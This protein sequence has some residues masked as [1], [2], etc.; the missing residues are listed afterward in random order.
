MP[1]L[2][3][4]AF[5]CLDVSPPLLTVPPASA[6]AQDHKLEQQQEAEIARRAREKEEAAAQREHVLHRRW[7]AVRASRTELTGSH[8]THQLPLCTLLTVA[9]A[10]RLCVCVTV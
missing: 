8:G 4:R 2:Y 10:P 9:H 7:G 5:P 3:D 1:P 6:G